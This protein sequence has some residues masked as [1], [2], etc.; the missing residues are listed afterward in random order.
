[1][2]AAYCSKMQHRSE[3][4]H[5]FPATGQ[6]LS[7][8]RSKRQRLLDDIVTQSVSTIGPP[9]HSKRCTRLPVRSHS[10]VYIPATLLRW[11]IAHLQT[12]L[13]FTMHLATQRVSPIPGTRLQP[14]MSLPHQEAHLGIL[15]ARSEMKRLS[16]IN[17]EIRGMKLQKSEAGEKGRRIAAALPRVNS[18]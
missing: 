8:A 15:A 3:T 10:N 18:Q 16:A 12:R 14:A 4:L 13:S 17:M 5:V 7:P 9:Y 1:M 2:D 11:I 6:P